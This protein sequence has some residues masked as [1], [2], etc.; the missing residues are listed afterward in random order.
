MIPEPMDEATE[1]LIRDLR[2]S[3]TDLARFVAAA[4]RRRRMIIAIAPEAIVRWERD[5]PSTWALVRQAL[6]A[7]G[8]RVRVMPPAPRPARPSEGGECL[9]LDH[10][11]A[12]VISRAESRTD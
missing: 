4:V 5:D 11:D 9:E 7:R 8:I 2:A 1:Q 3:P 6:A 12:T 10:F